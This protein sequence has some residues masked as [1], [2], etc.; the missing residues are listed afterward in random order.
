MSIGRERLINS[1]QS[2][3]HLPPLSKHG[4]SVVFFVG[5]HMDA[6]AASLASALCLEM[7][8]QVYKLGFEFL[9]LVAHSS[10]VDI[11]LLPELVDGPKHAC[12]KLL[13]KLP[14]VDDLILP[15]YGRSDLQI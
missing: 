6:D 14:L 2:W 7:I 3:P 10:A 8:S 9:N 4:H 15:N 12:A 13:I 1:R 5:R 11:S